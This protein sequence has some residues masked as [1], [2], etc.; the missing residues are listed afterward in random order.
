MKNHLIVCLAG[1]TVFVF[2]LAPFSLWSQSSDLLYFIELT[3]KEGV[4]FDPFTYFDSKALER[5][6]QQGLPLC[7]A[8]DYPLRVDYLNTLHSMADTILGVSRWFNAV[9]AVVLPEN[10]PAIHALEFVARIT[11]LTLRASVCGIKGKQP[12][13]FQLKLLNKQ[14]NR[15]GGAH[16]TAAGI[17]GSGVRIAIFDAGFPNVDTHEAFAHI[18][19][20]NRIIKTWDFVR[21]SEN[22][23]AYNAH[24]TSCLSC[25]AGKFGNIP[26]GLATGAEFLLARTE[27]MFEPY[28]EEY[29]WLAAAEWA[30]KNGADI[31]SSS[32]GYTYHR[33]FPDEMRGTSLVARAAN[34]AASKGI[35]VVNAM[36]NDGTDVSWKYLGTPADADSVLSVAGI[37]PETDYHINFS[38]FGPTAGGKRKPNVAAYGRAFLAQKSGFGDAYGTSFA[39]PLVSGFAA[40]ARQL[41]PDAG[42]ME[43]FH[44]IEKASD[45]YPYYDYAH[46]YG[47]PQAGRLLSTPHENTPPS[48]SFELVDKVLKVIV[49]NCVRHF[50]YPNSN[51]LYYQYVNEKDEILEY[52]VINVYSRVPLV[53]ER[54]EIPENATAVKVFYK[55]YVETFLLNR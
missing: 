34:K 20:E 27:Q 42:V 18:R 32:L 40:C 35:L 11:P 2:L 21:N 31:I 46:G 39:T 4:A 9:V 53:I 16:F 24:G 17:D 12:S 49:L 36:G 51:Y 55:G 26:V 8:S 19:A 14:T 7:D 15:M 33:Y 37:D 28:S 44:E 30:D 10:L 13:S 1:M 50:E 52:S 25:I 23:Y 54:H 3:D 38:S 6:A 22:V 47:V 41:L 45:L 43:L 5:R 29:N 48:F